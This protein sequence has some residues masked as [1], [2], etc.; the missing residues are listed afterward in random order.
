MTFKMAPAFIPEL[1][2]PQYA[3]E[4]ARWEEEVDELCWKQYRSPLDFSGEPTFSC[5]TATT[6]REKSKLI[7]IIHDATILLYDKT[8]SRIYA[9]DVLAI[10]RRLLVWRENLPEKIAN[11]GKKDVQMLPHV[12]SLQ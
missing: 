2:P 4:V 1:Q 5:L 6:N 9:E 7:E 10:Y 12:L 11:T 3:E 8:G